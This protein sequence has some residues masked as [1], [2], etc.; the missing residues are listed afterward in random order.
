MSAGGGMES[1]DHSKDIKEKRRRKWMGEEEMEESEEES[2]RQV[3]D[4]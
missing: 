4:D 3:P 2:E 1:K